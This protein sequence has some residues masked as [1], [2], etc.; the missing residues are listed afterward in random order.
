MGVSLRLGSPVEWLQDLL[1]VSCQNILN[2]R[3]SIQEFFPSLGN[4]AVKLSN[5][6]LF[7]RQNQSCS[8][9]EQPH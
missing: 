5:R 7:S 8:P 9:G 1:A 6:G 4:G 3:K 2:L